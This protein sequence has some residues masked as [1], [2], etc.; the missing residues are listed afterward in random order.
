MKNFKSILTLGMLF[1]STAGFAQFANNGSNHSSGNGSPLLIKDTKSY[2]RIYFGYNP[3]T[4][5]YDVKGVE[6]NTLNGLTFGYTQGISLSKKLPLF[7]EVGARFNFGFKSET[8]SDEDEDYYSTRASYDYDNDNDEE[9]SEDEKLKTTT[10]SIVIP[11]NVAY[12]LTFAGGDV[13][14][15]PFFG[16]TFKGNVLGKEKYEYEGEKE[17]ADFFDK[18]DMGGKDYVW[19]RFQAGW[20][21]GTNVDYKALSVGLHYGADF[22]EIAKKTKTKNWGIT[23]GYNF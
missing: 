16:I 22:N 4:I 6:D 3:M 17:T 7:L 21:I 20:Q 10:A 14:V 9:E 13:S 11:I 12:K 19:K 15:S 23:V 8:L 18:D 5:S 1:V 2:S